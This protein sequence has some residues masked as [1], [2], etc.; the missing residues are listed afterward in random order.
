[1][2]FWSDNTWSSVPSGQEC[3]QPYDPRA[4]EDANYL[5]SIGEEIYVSSP[6]E[7]SNI[8]KLT[9]KK[10]NFSIEPGQFAFLLSAE[11]VTIP[12]DAIGLISIRASIKFMG[13]VN[14]SGFHVDPGYSGKLI[15][16]VFNA[17][18]AR[19]H[20]Q[21]G[22]R[23]FPLW[24]AA[25][26]GP[27]KRITIKSGDEKIPPKL[28]TQI[29]GDFTTAYQLKTQLNKIKED[30]TELKAF[31]LQV[32]VVIVVLAA[33]L[34][35]VLKERIVEMFSQSREQSFH[36]IPAPTSTPNGAHAPSATS[37]P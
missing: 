6:E 23:I 21:K 35:P 31:K 5:L 36:S 13:L 15:F 32:L 29:S 33:I 34:F 27:I 25:L 26:D 4:L 16:A 37:P 18:P 12:F 19:I 2:S 9:D 20:L 24:L 10:P 11:R 17:G 3:V 14:I 28:V 30:V 7:R 22:Q 1:M 8:R